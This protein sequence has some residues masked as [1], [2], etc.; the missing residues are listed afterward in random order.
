[1]PIEFESCESSKLQLSSIHK[2]QKQSE[3]SQNTVFKFISIPI[4]F[5]TGQNQLPL[6][7]RKTQVLDFF[8]SVFFGSSLKYSSED[9]HWRY[10]KPG[11]TAQYGD[12]NLQLLNLWWYSEINFRW[13]YPRQLA[14]TEYKTGVFVTSTGGTWKS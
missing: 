9:C 6:N 2:P 7:P 12:E 4:F 14:V 10:S 3:F 13:R 8:M 1:M 5:Y 11:F